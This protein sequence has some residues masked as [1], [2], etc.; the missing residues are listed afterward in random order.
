MVPAARCETRMRFE[1]FRAWVEH[2][3]GDERWELIDG[4]AVPQSPQ[5]SR[6]QRIV[7]NICCRLDA[8]GERRDGHAL[9]GLGVLSAAMDDYA[10][11]PDVVVTCGPLGADGYTSD[12][13]LLAE[14][15]SP[16]TQQTD[17]GAKTMFYRTVPSLR[18]FLMVHQETAR[19]E[20]WRRGD[21]RWSMRGVGPDDTVDLPELDGTLAVSEIYAR[22]GI[23]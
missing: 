20:V 2:R 7:A 11:I 8:L 23:V 6:H 13:V 9:P 1:E 4:A 3:P 15:L 5:T 22:A 16:S 17:L 18:V 21:A 14:V 12:P 10:P 19:V